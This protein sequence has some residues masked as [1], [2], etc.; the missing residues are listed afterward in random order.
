MKIDR[1]PLP[2]LAK[3]THDSRTTDTSVMGIGA[4]PPGNWS[5]SMRPHQQHPNDQRANVKNPNNQSF[6]AD[7][8]NRGKQAQGNAPGQMNA[9]GYE[10]AGTQGE[11]Q[12]TRQQTP[13]QNPQQN[14]ENPRQQQQRTPGR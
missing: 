5:V 2:L 10:G 11:Q 12:Q 3:A 8:A 13:Q 1:D 14:Q 4:H 9:P 7:Q 6:Q